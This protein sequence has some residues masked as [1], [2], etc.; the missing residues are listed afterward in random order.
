MQEQIELNHIDKVINNELNTYNSYY[1]IPYHAIRNVFD[2]RFDAS[3]KT[4]S[5]SLNEILK[6]GPTLQKDFMNIILV[7]EN[8][9]LD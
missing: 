9:K 1:D 2:A 3:K 5:V 7:G 4:K 8:I 6:N